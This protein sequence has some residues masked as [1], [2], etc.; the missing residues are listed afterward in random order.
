LQNAIESVQSDVVAIETPSLG[1]DE[2]T[3]VQDVGTVAQD[4]GTVRQDEGTFQQDKSSGTNPCGDIT[5]AYGDAQGAYADGEAMLSDAKGGVGDDISQQR[6]AMAAAPADWAAYWRAQHAVPWYPTETI[7]PLKLVLASGQHVDNG[8][9]GNV[10]GDVNKANSY[11][12]QAYEIVNT[13]NKQNHCGSLQSIPVLG[14]VSVAWLT[15]Y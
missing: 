12:A 11:I 15:S 3:F 14:H 5:S 13:A 8:A 10:N 1:E 4:L 6:Q 2:S 9:V 7:P